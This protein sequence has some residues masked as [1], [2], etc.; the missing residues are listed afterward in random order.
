MI[1][2]REVQKARLKRV[3]TLGHFRAPVSVKAWPREDDTALCHPTIRWGSVCFL[4]YSHGLGLRVF[5]FFAH[6][7][8]SL[9][10]LHHGLFYAASPC[11]EAPE[12]A[13]PAR[14]ACSPKSSRAPARRT[15][16]S[17]LGIRP[18]SFRIRP[19][20]ERSC[21]MALILHASR[22]RAQ[23]MSPRRAKELRQGQASNASAPS[24]RRLA[25]AGRPC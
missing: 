2:P 10:R 9:T 11:G 21:G 20:A 7:G 18:L 1:L 16:T 13:L 4:R 22:R 24:R 8:R 3:F 5:A 15:I 12:F 6:T 23:N 19:R 14:Q 17:S 25:E